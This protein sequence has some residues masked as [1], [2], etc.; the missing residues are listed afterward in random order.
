MVISLQICHQK[1]LETK[2]VLIATQEHASWMF[3]SCTSQLSVT[4]PSL[5]LV[6]GYGTVVT[7]LRPTQCHSSAMN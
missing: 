4:E 2:F 1:L 3:P 5:S 6:L 7:L